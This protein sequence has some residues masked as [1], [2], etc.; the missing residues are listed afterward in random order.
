MFDDDESKYKLQETKVFGHSY[1]LELKE[2]ILGEPNG[3]IES[4]ADAKKNVHIQLTHLLD[5]KS[6]LLN[7]QNMPDDSEKPLCQ[8]KTAQYHQ[9]VHHANA[10]AELRRLQKPPSQH[11]G[12]GCQTTPCLWLKCL[13]ESLKHKLLVRGVDPYRC[14]GFW[15]IFVCGG[16][17]TGAAES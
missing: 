6:K 1:L 17:Q 8:K 9:L 7:M 14:C 3:E 16:S 11:Y 4:M 15:V 5:S 2:T 13:A 10:P 12:T